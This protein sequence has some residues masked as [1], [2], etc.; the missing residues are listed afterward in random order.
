MRKKRIQ[1]RHGLLMLLA[2]VICACSSV[3]CPMN[4][5][6]YTVYRLYKA[7]GVADTLK[8][9]LSVVTFQKTPEQDAVLLNKLANV[10]EFY[11]PVSYQ[12]TED[13][14]Y[15]LFTDTEVIDTVTI[16]KE[17]RK[18]FESINCNP[19]FFHTITGVEH[20]KN[21]I[22]SIIVNNPE[23]TYDKGKAH[24]HIYLRADR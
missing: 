5:S 14:L 23:V 12:Q 7:N 4:S 10:S 2:L 3:D 6:I 8:D 1:Y 9:S 11:L 17:N 18:H 15:F 20:T 19:S 16:K 24:F 21:R 22:D 13:I